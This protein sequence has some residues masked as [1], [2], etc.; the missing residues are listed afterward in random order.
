[1]RY[2]SLVTP[3]ILL[4]LSIGI[5]DAQVFRGFVIDAPGC[6]VRVYRQSPWAADEV[7]TITDGQGYW[8][9][10]CRGFQIPLNLGHRFDVD[11]GWNLGYCMTL[12]WRRGRDTIEVLPDVCLDQFTVCIKDIID[13]SHVAGD[14]KL[15]Y[16]LM[17]GSGRS[18]KPILV[19]TGRTEEA[20]FDI[21][22]PLPRHRVFPN[23]VL[24]LKLFK[25]FGAAQESLVCTERTYELCT[26]RNAQVLDEQLWFPEQ[27]TAW[28][29]QNQITRNGLAA[30]MKANRRTTRT[31]M[32]LAAQSSSHERPKGV[33][34]NALGQR[35]PEGKVD[36]LRSGTYFLVTNDPPTIRKYVISR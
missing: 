7:R 27:R 32:L 25:T 20:F 33:L 6:S 30:R 26:G 17:P 14:L 12:G 15:Y 31:A 35:V 36:Q 28:Q 16:Q 2:F 3:L 19:D 5:G 21:H 13:S 34:F 1:M 22:L 8:E 23:S 29:R 10:D 4:C 24:Y 18:F 9:A 11:Y